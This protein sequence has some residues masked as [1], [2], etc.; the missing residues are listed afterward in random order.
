MGRSV[1]AGGLAERLAHSHDQPHW[2]TLE[3]RCLACGNCTLVC[4]TCFCVTVADHTDLT[5]ATSDHVRRWDSCFAP[6]FSYIHGGAVRES[7]A[8]RYRHWLLHKLSTWVDQYGTPGCVGCG[9]C[10]TWCPVAIDLTAEVAA[11]TNR[12]GKE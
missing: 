6:D 12:R 10:L 1:E 9:R 8:A 11:V 3:E 2:Q 7:I 5:G 4:P